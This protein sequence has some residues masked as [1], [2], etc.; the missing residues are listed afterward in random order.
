MNAITILIPTCNRPDSLAV[1]LTSL[2]AQTFSDF[3]V[4]ISDQSDES[5]TRNGSLL[6]AIRVL[7]AHGNTVEIYKHLPKRGVA[8]QR[9]FLLD[10][11]ESPYS[12][13]M[14]DD[15]ILEPWVVRTMFET[16]TQTRCG[17][18]GQAPIGLSF[19]HD[20]RPQEQ[21]VAFWEETVTPEDVRPKS[22]KWQRY[23]LHSA[24]NIYHVQNLLRLTPEKRKLYKIAWIG[25]CVLYDTQKLRD[26]RGFRFWRQLPKDHCGEDVLVELR[27]MRR[28]GG[29]GMLPSGVYH[30]E[31]PT[32]L[33]ERNVNAPEVLI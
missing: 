28:Y 2:A 18:V 25:G 30:Q 17:F 22:A 29:C 21:Q 6:A 9:Q 1:L 12:L 27:V 14:D 24:A 33:P 5:I 7:K 31:V 16:I 3:S 8:E 11:S 23:K 4:I 15:L 13:F 10:H 32:T 26:C 19:V 20:F